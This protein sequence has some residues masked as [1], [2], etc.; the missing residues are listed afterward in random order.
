MQM[1]AFVG[2]VAIMVL[3]LIISDKF[4]P[5]PQWM[6]KRIQDIAFARARAQLFVFATYLRATIEEVVEE[7]VWLSSIGYIWDEAGSLKEYSAE[8]EEVVCWGWCRFPD[9]SYDSLA[10]TVEGNKRLLGFS[11]ERCK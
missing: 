4:A 1:L 10:V 2:P 6:Q 9:G 3:F 5:K 7:E 8:W 11:Y